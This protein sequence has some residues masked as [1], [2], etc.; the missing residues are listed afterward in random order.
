[1]TALYPCPTAAIPPKYAFQVT[2]RGPL[3]GRRDRDLV[4]A[5]LSNYG[6]RAPQR[7]AEAAHIGARRG[8][9]VS[10]TGA[11]I[12]SADGGGCGRPGGPSPGPRARE[13][14]EAALASTPRVGR[15]LVAAA[16]AQHGDRAVVADCC[17][18]SVVGSGRWG[19][20]GF[21]GHGSG[22]GLGAM[23]VKTAVLMNAAAI[24]R[25]RRRI[26]TPRTMT[27]HWGS[28]AGT[29]R[30]RA[31]PAGCQSHS[32]VCRTNGSRPCGRLDF[33]APLSG[34][35]TV[36]PT[37]QLFRSVLEYTLQSEHG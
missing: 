32:G 35:G 31:A 23:A 19:L 30:G 10:R 25:L 29:L 21:P 16:R 2:L 9:A 24:A 3:A 18:T 22:H 37:G 28:A 6:F 26:W 34:V 7:S 36:H 27:G 13:E 33:V 17:G 4:L 12:L 1:M 5:Q 11:E 14:A 8:P 15:L 20:A